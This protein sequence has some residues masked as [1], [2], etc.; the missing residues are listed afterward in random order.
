MGIVDLM[1]YTGIPDLNLQTTQQVLSW[2]ADNIT[3]LAEP[4]GENHQQNPGLTYALKTG[5]CEDF[6]ILCLFLL[7]RDANITGRMIIGTKITTGLRHAWIDV[8][9]SWYE[10]QNARLSNYYHE[11]YNCFY[12]YAYDQLLGGYEL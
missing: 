5:D 2:V 11:I 12:F 1:F 4:A 6:S 3:Y 9:N 7:H 8:D 10:P